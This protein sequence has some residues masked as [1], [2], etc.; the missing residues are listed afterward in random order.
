MIKLMTAVQERL[1][2]RYRL[3]EQIA[4][5]GMGSVWRAR[6]ELL[7]RTVAVKILSEELSH[8]ERAAERFRREA[9]IAASLSHPR[10]ANVFD[11][12]EGAG[13][14]GIVMEYVESETL[15]A[16]LARDR[17]L[18]IAE[19]TRIIDAMLEAL[20]AAHRAGVVHRDVKPGN[21]LL[22]PGGDVKVADFGIA[23]TLGDASLTQTGAIMGTAAYAAPEQIRGHAASASCDIYSAGIVFYEML[24]GARPF[25]GDSAAAVALA[26]L[27][28]D[29]VPPRTLRHAIP[30]ALDGVVMRALARDPADRFASAEEMRAALRRKDDATE[31]LLIGASDQTVNLGTLAPSP[32]R[33]TRAHVPTVLRRLLTVTLVP[34]FL[35]A[36]VAV[37][38]AA[39]GSSAPPTVANAAPKNPAT[40]CCSVPR[41]VGLSLVNAEIALARANLTLGTVASYISSATPGTILSQNRAPG[42]TIGEGGVVNVA[43]AKAPPPRQK[44]RKHGGD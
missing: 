19:A 35:V 17:I 20:D 12:V 31:V 8:D 14:P 16:R 38:V 15:S 42:S 41:L 2:D 34:L 30:I 40:A 39:T 7:G 33:E 4:T 29:P 25:M 27:S 36:S 28:V 23:R 26:R 22:T 3:E 6:D 18:P 43:V 13:R 9:R 5:G 10:M 37:I 11:L 44:H 24:T 1:A 32:G 21:V